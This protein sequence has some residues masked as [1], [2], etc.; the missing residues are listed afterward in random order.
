MDSAIWIN[1]KRELRFARLAR[2]GRENDPK[3]LAVFDKHDKRE[4]EIFDFAKLE[5]MTDIRIANNSSVKS[6][7]REIDRAMKLLL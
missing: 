4:R 1:S 7:E 6:L 3:T 5:K 2:R